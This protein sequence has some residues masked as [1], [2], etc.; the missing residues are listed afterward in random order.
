MGYSLLAL[1]LATAAPT[2]GVNDPVAQAPAGSCQAIAGELA[3]TQNAFP[4][5]YPGTQITSAKQ[6]NKIIRDHPYG[7]AI[8]ID[9]GDFTGWRFGKKWKSGKRFLNNVCFLRS[10]LTNTNWSNAK[11]S[12]LG[13]ID[14]NLTG[15]NMEE[16]E[17]PYTLF[18]NT[19]LMDVS[20]KEADFSYGRLDGGWKNSIANLVL[21]EA[22]LT[23]FRFVCGVKEIDGCPFERK[24]INARRANFTNASIMGFYV[25]DMD[26]NQ[27]RIDGIEL[28]VDQLDQLS[29]AQTFGP[30]RLRGG[31]FVQVATAAEFNALRATLRAPAAP[32]TRCNDPVDPLMIAICADT[33]RQLLAMNDD[34]A[35]LSAGK[36]LPKGPAKKFSKNRQKCFK[37]KTD[38]TRTACLLGI[39][40]DWRAE[41]IAG[42]PPPAWS[43]QPAKIIYARSNLPIN[44][45]PVASAL[46]SRFGAVV[47]GSASA[48]VAAKSDGA[49]SVSMRGKSTAV[50]GEYCQFDVANLGYANGS[51]GNRTAPAAEVDT[52][53][54]KKKAKK[55]KGGSDLTPFAFVLG[56]QAQ[57]YA[58][59]T[60]PKVYVSGG[61]PTGDTVQC[62]GPAPFGKMQQLQVDATAFDLIWNQSA[63]A[64][65]PVTP[66][67]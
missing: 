40:D 33:S 7:Q 65:P 39:Y 52:G 6:F 22:D 9:G 2:P 1:A 8:V 23:G 57:V 16:A 18:R 66:T 30:V 25:N 32:E 56:E 4:L 54:K 31:P 28:G 42:A 20:A 51:F 21:E 61:G 14:T 47:A 58:D 26:L 10:N 43:Q 12:G 19:T 53:K 15:A 13:F 63:A 55:K 37:Q 44:K 50:D 45:D 35:I 67:Q 38:E 34:I 27:A 11:G 48:F 60:G 5:A 64:S 29:G 36:I 59:R 24:G 41:L 17:L 3:N 49:G 62:T 46:W